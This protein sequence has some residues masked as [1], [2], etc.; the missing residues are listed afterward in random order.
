MFSTKGVEAPSSQPHEVDTPSDSMALLPS[1]QPNHC[2][3]CCMSFESSAD[4][5]NHKAK[6][7]VQSEYFD[8]VKLQQ[9][10]LA[11]TTAD[12]NNATT[13]KVY[14]ATMS[15]ARVQQ[16]LSGGGGSRGDGGGGVDTFLG[17]VSLLDLKSTLQ[18]NDMEMEKLR[19][20]VKNEREK[21]KADELRA[22]K[23]KQQKVFLQKK[24]EEDEVVA[25]MKEIE[26]RQ[27]EELKARAQ[28]EQVKAELR[29]LDTVGMAHLEDERKRELAELVKQREILAQKEQAALQEIQAMEMRVKEQE[30]QHRAEEQQVQAAIQRLDDGAKGDARLRALRATHMQRSQSFGAKAA[31]LE[32]KRLELQQLQAKIKHDLIHLHTEKPRG[33]NQT[34]ETNV[35]MVT[36]SFNYDAEKRRLD[37]LEMKFEADVKSQAAS[38]LEL[39]SSSKLPPSAS[40]TGTSLT[41]DDAIPDVSVPSSNDTRGAIKQVPSSPAKMCPETMPEGGGTSPVQEPLQASDTLA[42]TT[43]MDSLEREVLHR[44]Q[45]DHAFKQSK[46]STPRQSPAPPSPNPANSG[47]PYA[48]PPMATSTYPEPPHAMP[49]MAP[50]MWPPPNTT[51][52]PPHGGQFSYYTPPPAYYGMYQPPMPYYNGYTGFAATGAAIVGGG[53]P[54]PMMGAPYAMPIHPP[55]YVMPNM[56]MPNS[57][58]FEPPPDP[59]TVKLQQQLDAMKLLKD[60]REVEMETLRFQQMIQSIQAKLP[61]AGSNNACNVAPN[62][63]ESMSAQSSSTDLAQKAPDAADE[64]ESKELKALKLKHAED[65]L[66]L[67]QQRDLMEEEERLQDLKEQ[68]DKRRRDMEEQLAQDEWMANQNRMV[69]ALRMKKMLAQEQPLTASLMTDDMDSIGLPLPYD[70]DVGFTVFWDYILLVP[71]KATF[72]QVTYA[73]YEGEILRTKHKVLR[74]RECEPYGPT[75]NRCVLASS[76]AFDHLPASQDV[77]LLIEVAVMPTDGKPVSLGWTM[78]DLFAPSEGSAPQLHEGRFKLPLSHSPMPQMTRGPIQKPDSSSLTDATT[79]YLRVVHAGHADDAAKYPVNPDLTASKYQTPSAAPSNPTSPSPATIVEPL[80]KANQPGMEPHRSAQ[81]TAPPTRPP[82]SKPQPVASFIPATSSTPPTTKSPLRSAVPTAM[83]V[84]ATIPSMPDNDA[85]LYSVVLSSLQPSSPEEWMHVGADCVQLVLTSPTRASPLYSSE[86][87]PIEPSTGLVASGAAWRAPWLSCPRNQPMLLTMLHKRSGGVVDTYNATLPLENKEGVPIIWD[88]QIVDL[89]HPATKQVKATIAVTLTP[90]DSNGQAI[91]SSTRRPHVGRE[92]SSGEGW[93]DCD[94][95]SN[96]RST[97][98]RPLF[99]RGDGFNV[100]VDGARS[101]PDIVTITKVTCFAL[102]ADMGNVPP[103]QDPSAFASLHDNAFSPSFQLGLEF[104]GD[105]FNPT[106]TLLCRVDT[107]HSISKQAMVVGY[108]VLP[109]F[110]EHDENRAA[111]TPPTKATVQEFHLNAGAFQLPLRLGATLGTDRVD[112]TS[113]ACDSF[114]KL[115]CATLLVRVCPAVKSEDGLSCLSRKDVPEADWAARGIAVP[116]PA[117]AEKVYDSTSSRP[118]LTEDKLYKLRLHRSLR[119]VSD[120]LL[121]VTEKATLDS[122]DKLTTWLQ[123]QLNKKPP[124][125][126]LDNLAMVFPYRPEM[127]FRVAVDGLVNAPPGCLY[128]VISCISPPA[129]FYQD[130]KMT[131]DVHMTI[132]YDWTSA[133]SHPQFSDGFISYRDVPEFHNTDLLVVFDVRGVKQVKGAWVSHQVGWT[134]LKLLNEAHCIAAGSFQL[135]VFAGALSLDLLQHDLAL[136]ALV[137][138]E[139]PKKKGLISYVQGMSVCVRV[140]DGCMP[141]TFPKPLVGLTPVGIPPATASKYTYDPAAVAAQQKKKPLGKLVIGKTERDCEKELNIAFAKDM[142]ISHYTF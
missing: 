40:V 118:S 124:A 4:Y 121:A 97:G 31:L 106:L 122:P 46:Q 21:E 54:P 133:Q 35:H 126:L 89:C 123:S 105:R 34:D 16:Y 125:A 7:C 101:L 38:I 63:G 117:Y 130:P 94:L 59:E 135:P 127:G 139:T 58:L 113:K 44:K 18:A 13:G 112:F 111:T 137:A 107:I 10:L 136:D 69:M 78:L 129:P 140:E 51:Y 128:K 108:A 23:L 77:R 49:Q 90:H 55:P 42:P 22:L 93:I 75:V 109:V 68:R 2:A 99:S 100:Y 142:A 66:K 120:V 52:L 47:A 24:Q 3:D 43:I 131:D 83:A 79:L 9:H 36:K 11:T 50:P 104:R 17:K 76:R 20:H 132:S 72:L 56:M 95:Y 61:G 32:R 102:N 71:L 6:F 119:L 138:L 29:Q 57:G 134:Y 12:D 53:Y 96:P 15:F 14:A 81:S 48:P 64:F 82:T 26:R 45:S 5:A 91:A 110:L 80:K 67:K 39:E 25:L 33:D 30:M 98:H 27:L 37:E 86:D 65:M 73:V 88:D 62:H 60:Q 115:P 74:G 84:L 70:P 103:L 8:P 87:R 92:V 141:N 116:A 19:R 114:M 41:S 85:S 28:R 1:C